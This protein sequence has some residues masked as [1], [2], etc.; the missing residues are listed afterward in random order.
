MRKRAILVTLAAF[1][2]VGLAL[3][4]FFVLLMRPDLL[5]TYAGRP[6]PLATAIALSPWFVPASA[7]IGVLLSVGA[8]LPRW[9]ARTRTYL[10]A[11]GIVCT[12]FGLAFAVAASYAPLFEEL[13]ALGALAVS[14]TRIGG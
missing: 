4:C 14:D 6:A 5:A 11:S 13:G 9:G 3:S 12:V 8:W 7:A 2:L 1:E 10:S